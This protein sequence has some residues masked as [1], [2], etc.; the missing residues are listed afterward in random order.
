M[1]EEEATSW[2]RQLNYWYLYFGFLDEYFELIHSI[3][4]TDSTWTDAGLYVFSGTIDRRSGF[5][6]HPKYLEVAEA[7]GI[8]DVWEKRGP[9]DFCEKVGGKWVC[10]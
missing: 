7:T 3:G 9:P 1:P 2:Q 8:V 5:T 6:A 10:E 4:L